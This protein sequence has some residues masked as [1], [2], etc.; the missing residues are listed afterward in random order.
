MFWL[1]ELFPKLVE[2]VRHEFVAGAFCFG[3]IL[4][5]EREGFMIFPE[6]VSVGS[7]RRAGLKGH[8]QFTE[9][10]EEFT[11]THPRQTHE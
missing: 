6:S 7:I 2:G 3:G 10:F 9:M 1:V 8:T 5:A 4:Q 11:T